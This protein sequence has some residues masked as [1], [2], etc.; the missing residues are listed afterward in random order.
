VRNPYKYYLSS[1]TWSSTH[2]FFGEVPEE[3]MATAPVP[4]ESAEDKARFRRLLTGRLD[5]GFGIGP[6][7]AHVFRHYLQPANQPANEI[8]SFL[9]WPVQPNA[10]TL[11]AWRAERIA[12]VRSARKEL[13]LLPNYEDTH[14]GAT[15]GHVSC[16]VHSENLA[17][18]LRYCLQLYEA[19]ARKQVVNWKVFD[20]I[21]MLGPAN[22]SPH[23]ACEEV[24]TEELY[25]LVEHADADLIRAF[26]Y[27]RCV[28][29]NSTQP[30]ANKLALLEKVKQRAMPQTPM[31]G[32]PSAI[33]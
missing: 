25:Q 12:L 29:R 20:H 1:W 8:G 10:S 16:W 6:L 27:T 2:K 22:E 14:L 13:S 21:V 5:P 15:D 31:S 7:S 23:A 26:G 33:L 17:A 30:N 9:P 3:Y 32:L 18:D 24:F 19:I 4:G 11:A 28:G